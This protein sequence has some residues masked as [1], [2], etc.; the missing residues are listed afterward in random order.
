MK[1][2]VICSWRPANG[3][4][5]C[6]V[7]DSKIEADKRHQK[8]EQ[9]KHFLTYRGHVIGLYPNGGGTL[10]AKLLNRNPEKLPKPKTIDLNRYCEGFTREKI[11]AFK[12]CVLQLACLIIR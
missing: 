4:G 7:C 11:K 12:K 6:A 9:P 3:N 8:P 1:K 10:K 2:C 5:R